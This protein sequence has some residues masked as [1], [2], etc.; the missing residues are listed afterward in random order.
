MNVHLVDAAKELYKNGQLLTR[1]RGL[2]LSAAEKAERL[3]TARTIMDEARHV[4]VSKR[5]L[6]TMVGLRSAEFVSSGKC[7]VSA[8]RLADLREA[9]EAAKFVIASKR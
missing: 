6:C 5:A 4:G 2:V 3:A 1:A 7:K 8:S 9:L